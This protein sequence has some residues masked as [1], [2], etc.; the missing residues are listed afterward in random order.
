MI[1]L[2]DQVMDVLDKEYLINLITKIIDALGS[3]EEIDANIEELK[4]LSLMPNVT[5]L[6]FYPTDYVMTVEDIAN[7]ILTFKPI[8]LE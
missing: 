7:M 1:Y 6:I 5:D 8:R 2:L 3:E 4:N